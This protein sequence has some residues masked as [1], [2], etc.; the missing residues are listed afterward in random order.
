MKVG[1]LIR[2][3][4]KKNLGLPT[5]D[6]GIVIGVYEHPSDDSHDIDILWCDGVVYTHQFPD[7][8]IEVINES[9]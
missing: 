9:R 6:I 5:E 8:F 3:C 7:N 4:P 1:D 2:Y